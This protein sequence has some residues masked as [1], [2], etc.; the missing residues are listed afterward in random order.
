MN[1]MCLGERGSQDG[2]SSALRLG[3]ASQR[4]PTQPGPSDE[5]PLLWHLTSARPH[6]IDLVHDVVYVE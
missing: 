3:G 1:V 4:E 6:N 2:V 5:A